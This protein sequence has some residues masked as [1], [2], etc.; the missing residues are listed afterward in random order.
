MSEIIEVTTERLHL[1]QWREADRELFADL[2]ADPRV[3]EFFP[4]TLP[5][6]ASKAAAER[7]EALI[8]QQGWGPW[9]VEIRETGEF[10]GFVGLKEPSPP[11]SFSP[12]VEVAWRLAHAYWGKGYATEAANAAL[13]IGFEKLH[14]NEIVSFT[15]VI[16]KR[17]EAVMQRLGMSK[18]SSTFMH[19]A[20]PDGHPLKE[21]CLYRLSRN[22]W[23]A[24]HVS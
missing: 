16:N 10:I 15:A 17:S 11:L 6:E 18:E 19:P 8:A 4:S 7:W 1:R 24:R 5:R 9:A 12:C 13:R 23:A 22:E 21:H 20:V 3:I 14:L 2:N